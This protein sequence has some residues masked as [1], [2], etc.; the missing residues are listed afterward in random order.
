MINF[1]KNSVF[2]YVF[3]TSILLLLSLHP[4]ITSFSR[5]NDASSLVEEEE[6]EEVV[7][8]WWLVL[9]FPMK[10]WDELSIDF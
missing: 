9:M 8:W 10:L 7:V 2:F 1:N 4:M 6:E 3:C 5:N